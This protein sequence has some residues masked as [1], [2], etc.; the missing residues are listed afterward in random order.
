M[1]AKLTKVNLIKVS[2]FPDCDFKK[3]FTTDFELIFSPP[4][5]KIQ[6]SLSFKIIPQDYEDESPENFMM[7]ELYINYSKDMT[8]ISL[9]S[10]K[11]PK[12]DNNINQ[13]IN[14]EF[15]KI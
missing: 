9:S 6:Y 8:P 5:E 13:K 4:D 2:N 3:D 1:S 10:E 11:H 15:S 14:Y 12:F 7:E